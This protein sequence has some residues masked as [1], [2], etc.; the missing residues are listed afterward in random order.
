MTVW[1][2]QISRMSA[3]P[4]NQPILGEKEPVELILALT[5]SVRAR[6]F[7]PASLALSRLSATAQCTAN[8]VHCGPE[9]F[10]KLI[11]NLQPENKSLE[12]RQNSLTVVINMVKVGAL[13]AKQTAMDAIRT[14]MVS[15]M[16]KTE[17]VRGGGIPAL[18]QVES[19]GNRCRYSV[20]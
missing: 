10:G 16:F 6:V 20:E 7:E 2:V 12:L 17:F 8:I 1:L 11:K 18:K 3:V 13:P 14:L 9:V 5:N 15:D 4:Q 19:R